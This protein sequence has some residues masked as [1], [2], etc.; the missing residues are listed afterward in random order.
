[1]VKQ[2]YDYYL[3]SLNSDRFFKKVFASDR[4]AKAFLEDFLNIEITEIERI[5]KLDAYLTDEADLVKFDYRCTINNKQVIIEMQ[6]WHK[7][8]I[9]RRFYLYHALNSG[10]QVENLPRKIVGYNEKTGQPIKVKDYSQ[11]KPAI[12]LIW[13][14]DE[15][16]GYFMDY[17]T[18]RLAPE[19]IIDFVKNNDIW[20]HDNVEK[21]IKT[22][23]ELVDIM[24]N[25]TKDLQFL[26]ENSLTFIFQ[27]N[28]IKNP[29]I[30]KY[31]RWFS[32][33]ERSKNVHNKSTDFTDFESDSVFKEVIHRL[34]TKNLKP[35]EIKEYEDEVETETLFK[36]FLNETR[37]QGEQI[38][39]KKGEEIGIKKGEEIGIK[40]GEEIGIKKGEEI[41]ELKTMLK[42]AI[43][44]LKAGNDDS[45]IISITGLKADILLEI[46]QLLLSNSEITVN[47]ILNT[48]N[49]S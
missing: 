37:K 16:L 43:N 23:A 41:G 9:V 19:K 32:F 2:K 13:L 35:D 42:I 1:M 28:I 27:P 8:D 18:F 26:P 5:D 24:N 36:K 46:R 7:T 15:T 30:E 33:A 44:M 29:H 10:L 45:M 40:K 12:T 25:N 6:Q 48:L 34:G 47:E 21:L 20:N 14:V 49:L 17:A 22:R 11:L 3:V 4:I 38:G 39:I 31:S